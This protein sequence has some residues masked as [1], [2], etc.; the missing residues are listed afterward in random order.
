MTRAGVAGS[1]QWPAGRVALAGDKPQR[2]TSLFRPSA[3][4]ARAMVVGVVGRAGRRVTLRL[5]TQVPLSS[6]MRNPASVIVQESDDE[7]TWGCESGQRRARYFSSNSLLP[8]EMTKAP[9]PSLVS[10]QI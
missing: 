2:Y 9:G 5:G 1:P 6:G 8:I 10:V 7:R 3:V 4:A